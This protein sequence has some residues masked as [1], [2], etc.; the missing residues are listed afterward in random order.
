MNWNAAGKTYSWQQYK[1]PDGFGMGTLG[2]IYEL[3][4][5]GQIDEPT[6][7]QLMKDAIAAI[8]TLEFDYRHKSGAAPGGNPSPAQPLFR[9]TN[10][11]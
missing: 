7:E 6:F 5:S 4:A 1:L 10:K 3:L 11:T 8:P 2:Q 9:K